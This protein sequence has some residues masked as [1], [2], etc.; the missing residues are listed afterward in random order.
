MRVPTPPMVP[1]LMLMPDDPALDAA[2][3]KAAVV[4]ITVPGGHEFPVWPLWHG[5]ALHV[6]H[7]GG[8][9]AAPGLSGST[10][11]TVAVPAKGAR[12]LVA[13]FLARVEPVDPESAEWATV[14]P[15]LLPKRLNLRDPATAVARWAA[16]SSV[17]TL[18][19]IG[20]P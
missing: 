12:E 10:T 7:G 16:E 6:L 18:V 17:S 11:A 9:Q 3:R 1:P 14:T 15:L 13:T 19:P 2:M 4:W 8:E 5:G 20:P